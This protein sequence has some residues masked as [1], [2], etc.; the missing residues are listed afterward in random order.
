MASQLPHAPV[1][2]SAWLGPNPLVVVKAAA[3]SRPALMPEVKVAK[4]E[5]S[6]AAMTTSTS[7]LGEEWK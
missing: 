2:E 6:M 5:A 3:Q 7:Y 1:S 4:M